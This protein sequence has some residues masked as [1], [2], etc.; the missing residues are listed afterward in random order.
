M[1]QALSTFHSLEQS[2]FEAFRRCTFCGDAI[3]NF[4]AQCLL[5]IDERK[6]QQRRVTRDALGSKGYGVGAS[7]SSST[8]KIHLGTT[9]T[10]TLKDLVVP[11]AAQEIT[12]V[13]STLA[14]A[15]AQ[16]TVTEARSLLQK[17]YPD[18]LPLQPHHIRQA[19]SHRAQTGLDPGFFMQ[20]PQKHTFQA[21]SFNT[22]ETF[23]ATLAWQE[24]YDTANKTNT[25]NQ[26]SKVTSATNETKTDHKM[27]K[28]KACDAPEN[29]A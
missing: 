28:K 20:P 23:E 24:A 9:D 12:V 17:S 26:S 8:E 15:Y 18:H 5:H 11:N 6:R 22:D 16:R 14:K 13:V 3:A 10:L 27:D 1:A 19:H 2:R 25:T 21:S 29:N 7:F 4:I